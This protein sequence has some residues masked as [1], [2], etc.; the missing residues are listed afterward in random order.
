MEEDI[1]KWLGVGA[2][3]VPTV[4]KLQWRMTTP[5]KVCRAKHEH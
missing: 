2:P 5:I 3:N 1:A 4:Q